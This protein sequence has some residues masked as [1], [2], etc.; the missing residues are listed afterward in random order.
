MIASDGSEI[1]IPGLYLL[2]APGRRFFNLGKMPVGEYKAIRFDVGVDDSTNQKTDPS[3]Y[4]YQHP[5][6]LANA[7]MFH[8]DIYGY[9]FLKMEGLA[10]TTQ[11]AT[12]QP[13]APIDYQILTAPL[14]RTISL[15]MNFTVERNKDLLLNLDAEYANLFNG[16]DLQHELSTST[17]TNF[18][19]AEKIANNEVD[20][21]GWATFR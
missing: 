21:F 13:T 19:L 14:R 1:A 18:M 6:G 16:I 20:V 10:D 15:Q 4:P 7:D 12:G 9:T 5:L 17:F 3:D 8:D 11:A 2:V